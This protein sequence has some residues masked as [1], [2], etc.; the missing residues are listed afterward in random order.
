MS[1]EYIDH[2]VRI[3]LLEKI[4]AS[5]EERFNKIDDKLDLHFKWTMGTL[6]AFMLAIVGMFT[7]LFL[8][9]NQ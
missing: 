9:F 2:E 6:I 1:E 3:R 8:G 7:T 5:N 4:V